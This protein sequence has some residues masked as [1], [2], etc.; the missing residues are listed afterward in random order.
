MSLN[1]GYSFFYDLLTV[2]DTA[3]GSEDDAPELGTGV[4]RRRRRRRD[5]PDQVQRVKIEFRV[6]ELKSAVLMFSRTESSVHLIRVS[7][8]ESSLLV[9]T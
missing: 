6:V 2:Q 3:P 4:G 8:N 9:W 7:L 1:L 5:V